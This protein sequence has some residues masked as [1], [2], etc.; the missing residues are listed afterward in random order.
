[1]CTSEALLSGDAKAE[2]LGEVTEVK[3]TLVAPEREKKESP[4]TDEYH[5]L[6]RLDENARDGSPTNDMDEMKR[7]E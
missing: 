6:R 1:M 2:N 7:E 4:A 5:E 3:E